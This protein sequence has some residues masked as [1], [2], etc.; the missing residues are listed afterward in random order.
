[1]S[2]IDTALK[3]RPLRGADDADNALL[4]QPPPAQPL[5]ALVP[6][7]SEPALDLLA[8]LLKFDPRKRCTAQQALSHP[9]LADLHEEAA[10]P[11]APEPV[12]L[13]FEAD[14]SLDWKQLRSLYCQIAA[15]SCVV[16][17]A[18]VHAYERQQRESGGGTRAAADHTRRERPEPNGAPASASAPQRAVVAEDRRR[19][20]ET[21]ADGGREA[22]GGPDGEHGAP[23]P[24]KRARS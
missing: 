11:S 4:K 16:R 20:G 17:E 10:E 1:M 3:M 13:D 5:R 15:E 7:A 18:R 14:T 9:Y 22:E 19:D 2:A 23:G 12:S 24:A 21:R 8:Q 6:T